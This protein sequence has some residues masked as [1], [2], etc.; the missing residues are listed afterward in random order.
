MK[1]IFIPLL[2]L[3]LMSLHAQN[4]TRRD[5]LQ[6]GLRPER[7]AFNVLHYTLD[8]KID[9]DKKYI[10]GYNEISFEVLDD[11]KRIQLDLFE[12]MKVDSIIYNN[13]KMDPWER[14]Q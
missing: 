14:W 10:S 5:S 4:F 3:G 13:K 8:I 6:G 12:N 2:L 9:P 1:K 11:T 7:T